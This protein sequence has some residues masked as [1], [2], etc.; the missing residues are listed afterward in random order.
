VGGGGG[1]VLEEEVGPHPRIV[2]VCSAKPVA[3]HGGSPSGADEWQ[4]HP[5][6]HRPPK[7][8]SL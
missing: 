1:Q 5:E 8:S 7:N 3:K 6:V 4:E 2:V